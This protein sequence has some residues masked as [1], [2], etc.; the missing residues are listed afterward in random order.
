MESFFFFFLFFAPPPANPSPS[1]P[2]ASG[3]SH[4]SFF[5]PFKKKKR[6]PPVRVGVSSNRTR[7]DLTA[8]V[9]ARQ[10]E[11]KAPPTRRRFRPPPPS[12]VRVKVAH[13]SSAH[14]SGDSLRSLLSSH[15]PTLP[16]PHS[17]PPSNFS[18]YLFTY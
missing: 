17:L 10:R 14:P 5:R 2:P 13:T 6:R 3:M 16:H 4:V 9:A 11:D 15:P 1:P 18:T 12:T 8:G 7:L